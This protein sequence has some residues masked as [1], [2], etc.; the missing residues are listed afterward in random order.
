M[1][2]NELLSSLSEEV[3]KKLVEC[4]TQE[5]LRKVLDEAGIEP[6]DNELL[7]AVAGGYYGGGMQTPAPIIVTEQTS[8]V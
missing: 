1:K 7:D 8:Y 4:K 2:N 5:E 3:K 6:L